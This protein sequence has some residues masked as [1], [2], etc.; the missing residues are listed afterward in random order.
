MSSLRLFACL[1][2][3]CAPKKN[4]VLSTETRMDF[5]LSIW[6]HVQ[7]VFVIDTD[8]TTNIKSQLVSED[9]YRRGENSVSSRAAEGKRETFRP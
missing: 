4:V 8:V 3:T 1:D 7:E 9:G 2:F 5:Y 6:H